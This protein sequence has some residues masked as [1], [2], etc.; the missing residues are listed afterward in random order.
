VGGSEACLEDHGTSRHRH[1]VLAPAL[2]RL[3]AREI[4]AVSHIS[5]K[6]GTMID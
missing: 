3:Q 5:R 4:L 1:S 6:L 2:E